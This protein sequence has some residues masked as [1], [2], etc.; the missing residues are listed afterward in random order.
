[1]QK[2]PFS[3]APSVDPTLS[4]SSAPQALL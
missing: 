1:M 2:I 4:G 3:I